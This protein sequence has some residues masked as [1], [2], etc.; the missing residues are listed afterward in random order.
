MPGQAPITPQ[1][2]WSSPQP[3]SGA[4][5]YGYGGASFGYTPG[6]H[7]MV[8][9]A[10]GQR[11]PGTIHHVQGTRCLVVFPDGQQHWVE[12]QYIAPVG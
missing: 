11:Y 1:N 2:P 10:N 4:A 7:V 9:W 3:W 5:P 6:T 12:M 8:T